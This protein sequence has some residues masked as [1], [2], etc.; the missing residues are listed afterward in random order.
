MTVEASRTDLGDADARYA[1]WAWDARRAGLLD[2]AERARRQRERA[3]GPLVRRC[4]ERRA[5][6]SVA[7]VSD[8]LSGLLLDEEVAQLL[9]AAATGDARHT[10]RTARRLARASV[11]TMH[12]CTDEQPCGE[13]C[14]ESWG[15][16]VET[17]LQVVRRHLLP[18][19]AGLAT[20]HVGPAL[21]RAL[22]AMARDLSAGPAPDPSAPPPPPLADVHVLAGPA[23]QLAP[24]SR[25]VGRATEGLAA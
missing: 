25:H 9:R 15:A 14:R 19:L 21:R 23:C 1:A 20:E 6:V 12:V 4:G 24:P 8:S 17:I 13:A 7:A 22:L 10:E 2:Y 5:A 16:Q 11:S 18:F 3:T